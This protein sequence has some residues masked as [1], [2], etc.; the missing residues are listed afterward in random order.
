MNHARC[1]NSSANFASF[2]A[3]PSRRLVLEEV[4]AS[5]LS[6]SQFFGNGDR[7]NYG[8]IAKLLAAMQRQSKPVKP[9]ELGFIGKDHFAARFK[10]A[11]ADLKV[12]RY[13]RLSARR[14]ASRT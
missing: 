7:V 14:T 9:K 12:F 10:A 5:R 2:P 6:L 4:G 1:G 11:G 13:R 8:Q 3:A